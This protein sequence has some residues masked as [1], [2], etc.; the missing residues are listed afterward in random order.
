MISLGKET[1]HRYNEFIEWTDTLRDL[2]DNIWLTPIAE[3]KATV[4]EI[5]SHL[6]NWDHY[7][8]N[9]IIP[10][11][12]NGEGMVFPDFDSF[13]QKA[14]EYARS[15]VSKESM[16]DEFKQTRLQLIEILLTEPDV[17]AKHVTAN[18]VENCPHTGTPYSLL[19]IIHEFI[20]HDIHHKN[21]ILSVI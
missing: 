13:N 18:G 11:I 21:Q 3:G 9:T 4:A 1:I 16:L 20:E 10:A 17:T 14:Y 6:Q 5:I 12:K 15:G 19:Y 8:T 2:D 7:L